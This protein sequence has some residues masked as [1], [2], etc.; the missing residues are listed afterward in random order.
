LA[1]VLGIDRTAVNVKAKTNERLGFEGQEQG[2]QTQAV[3]LIS[4]I[5]NKV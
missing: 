1:A 3:A 4:R 2:I 5:P